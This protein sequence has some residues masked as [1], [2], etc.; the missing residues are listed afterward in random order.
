MKVV[1][2]IPARGG[3]KRLL[4]KNI[5]PIFNRPMMFWALQACRGSTYKIEPWVSS[6]DKE[7]I[8]VA[9]S[10]GAKIHSRPPDLAK[11]DTYKQAVI[12]A[13]AKEILETEEEKPDIWISLQ[14]NSPEIKSYHLDEAIDSLLVAERDE[15]FSVDWDLMQNAA[16]RVFR[17]DYVFQKDLSTNCGVYVCDI[18]DVHTQEDVDYIERARYISK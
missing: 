7:I 8:K 14:P 11:D 1:A 17:G 16:F 9:S 5:A 10:Y 12:R 3:S 4:R 18:K 2:I 15:I 13:A 6:E